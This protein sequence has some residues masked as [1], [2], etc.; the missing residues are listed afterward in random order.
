ARECKDWK[1]AVALLRILSKEAPEDTL[2]SIWL[3]EAT[4]LAL[5]E[6]RSA[7]AIETVAS[8]LAAGVA[9]L[10]PGVRLDAELLLEF[11]SLGGNMGGCEFGFFQRD[12]GAEPLSL[13]RWANVE[14]DDL[15]RAL[16]NGFRGIGEAEATV[17]SP[18]GHRDWQV[19]D[20]TY[21]IRIDHTHLDRDKVSLDEAKTSMTRRLRFLARDLIEELSEEQKIFVYKMTN[22]DFPV[23][24]ATDLFSVM[25]TYG[26][27]NKLLFVVHDSDISAPFVIEKIDRGLVIARIKHD[28]SQYGPINSDAWMALC[29][30]VHETLSH[31]AD[32]A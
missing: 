23:G 20:K 32:S 8:P 17:L 24:K 19:T 29:K 6:E 5:A 11:E 13:L 3:S 28:E 1:K 22:R 12:H 7:G 18:Q 10:S 4:E 27:N 16:K 15:A 31:G 9:D 21:N 30:R 25:K 14:P 26:E 2:V